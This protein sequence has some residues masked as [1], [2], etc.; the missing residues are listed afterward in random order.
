MNKRRVEI[1][2]P[3]PEEEVE[4]AAQLVEDPDTYEWSS[5]DWES[6]TTT[7]E[8]WPELA[9][10]T[11]EQK[12]ALKAG[13]IE[14]VTITLEH[15]TITWFKGQTGEE[16]EI[17]GTAWLALVEEAI[18]SYVKDRNENSNTAREI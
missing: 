11:R 14:Q 7:Q 10:R 9:R 1:A 12:A 2:R 6:A 3:T 16:G 15:D 17:G 13:Q 5:E 8:L 4:I 18:Q